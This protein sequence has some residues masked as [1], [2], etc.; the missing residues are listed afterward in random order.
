MEEEGINVLS[1]LIPLPWLLTLYIARLVYRIA[2]K[3]IR[4]LSVTSSSEIGTRYEL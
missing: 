1:L 3:I 2:D 4:M